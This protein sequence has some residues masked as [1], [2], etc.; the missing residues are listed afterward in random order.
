MK[1][2][3][4]EDIGGTCWGRLPDEAKDRWVEADEIAKLSNFVIYGDPRGDSSLETPERRGMSM[5]ELVN[6]C[7]NGGNR[8][9]M[10]QIFLIVV[11]GE[12]KDSKTCIL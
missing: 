5:E 11:N 12:V 6:W 1:T 4:V 9:F 8:D 2:I 10:T 7:G 3:A